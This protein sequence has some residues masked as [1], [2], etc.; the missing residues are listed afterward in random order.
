MTEPDTFLWSGITSGVKK[1]GKPDLGLAYSAYPATTAGVFTKNSLSAAPVRIDRE[2]LQDKR[3]FRGLVVNSGVANAATG[4]E[5]RQR[6]RSVINETAKTLGLE[7]DE[8]LAASTGHIGKPLP[9]DTI[10]GALPDSVD[11]LEESSDNFA[12]AIMTTDSTR[13]TVQRDVTDLNARMRGIAKG[14]GMIRPDMATMLAFVFFDH[15]VDPDWWQRTLER[16]CSESFNQITV[17]GE[18]STNDTV[19]AFGAR[20]PD[21]EPIDGSHD[22]AATVRE[23]LTAICESLARS[24]VLDGEGATQLIEI[25]VEGAPDAEAAETVADSTANSNLLKTAIYGGD[26]NW[27]RIY[28]AIGATTLDINEESLSISMNGYTLFE[29]PGDA[30]IAPPGLH[31]ELGDSDPVTIRIDLGNGS[32]TARRLT[33]DLTEE[34]IRI[35]SDYEP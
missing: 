10:T 27:G 11:A 28:S 15:P 5:G 26:P 18:M 19:L 9:V 24:I 25:T 30:S 23:S 35:N 22:A 33:C 31:E 29:G 2:R 17:D 21:R 3:T 6:C 20:R 14:A 4:E 12:D 32:S 16:A 7:S 8:V 1:S 13:K 34:Y